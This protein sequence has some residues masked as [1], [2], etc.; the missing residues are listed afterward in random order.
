MNNRL[1]VST[2]SNFPQTIRPQN[3]RFT[4]KIV[5]DGWEF[6]GQ[7]KTRNDAIA[8]AI[9]SANIIGGYILHLKE[10]ETATVKHPLLE[11]IES[12]KSVVVGM[13]KIVTKGA[14]KK[15]KEWRR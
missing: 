11:D 5:I 10:P 3:Q 12:L 6:S 1:E 4:S 8:V 14:W 15:L 2:V 13:T 9:N 7:G